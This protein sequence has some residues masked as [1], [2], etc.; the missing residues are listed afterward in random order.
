MPCI[1]PNANMRCLATCHPAAMH[2]LE[3]QQ[4]THHAVLHNLYNQMFVCCLD[5]QHVLKRLAH[6][7]LCSPQ[8]SDTT[9][10]HTPG[11]HLTGGVGQDEHQPEEV[12]AGVMEL[13]ASE[14]LE[15]PASRHL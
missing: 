1:L 10:A 14:R 9:A 2:A 5:M 6:T 3:A 12:S 8:V 13:L 15:R 11:S 7:L 4:Y